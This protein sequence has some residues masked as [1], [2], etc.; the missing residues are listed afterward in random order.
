[1]ANYGD[2][3]SLDETRFNDLIENSIGQNVRWFR[4]IGNS[5]DNPSA[6]AIHSF[7]P[8]STLPLIRGLLYAEQTLDALG[9]YAIAAPTASL[10]SGAGNL[11]AGVYQ[12]RVTFL[13]T[14]GESKAGA[15]G[16]ITIADPAANGHTLLQSI[17]T[18]PFGCIQKRRIYRTKANGSVFYYLAEIPD[19]YTD[20]FFDDV[21]DSGLSR[22]KAPESGELTARAYIYGAKRM[23]YEAGKGVIYEGDAS[24]NADASRTPFRQGDILVVTEWL[25]PEKQIVTRTVESYD[26]LAHWFASDLELVAQ[27]NTQLYAIGQDCTL[28]GSLAG[29]GQLEQSRII[30]QD[31]HNGP[32]EGENYV[33]QYRRQMVFEFAGQSRRPARLGSEGG[34]LPL[35]GVL[36]LRPPGK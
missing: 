4:A 32:A 24:I 29:I 20:I 33:V 7:E 34:F 28:D 2:V 9:D 16:A 6:N 31:G 3:T 10:M 12:Y 19:A 15:S 23:G 5:Q 35:R 11:S 14:L 30:W 1:M 36:L 17:P 27:E 21:P 25:E 13:N 8:Q 18:G 26:K 22:A